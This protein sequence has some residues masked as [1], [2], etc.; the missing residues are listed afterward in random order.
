M[1]VIAWDGKTLAAD[2]QVTSGYTKNKR[3]TKIRKFENVICGV[4]GESKY[5]DAL[6][7]WV[8]GG[9]IK[10]RFP[11]FSDDNQ[12][13]LVVIDDKELTE[14]WAS[15]FETKYPRNEIAAWGTGKELALGAMAA[16]A[17]AKKAVEIASEYNL[18]CGGGI[19][20]V[21]G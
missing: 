12:V 21:E 20:V 19:D 14:Y 2:R 5:A 1:T 8:E 15:T 13:M 6:F 11:S 9:R 3:T 16:G 4:T 7:K 17:D 10:E 18:Y